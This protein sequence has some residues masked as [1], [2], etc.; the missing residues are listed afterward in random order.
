MFNSVSS[1]S[2]YIASIILFLVGFY[3]V[4]ARPNLIK[5]IIGINI[6]ETSVFLF[7]IGIGTKKNG[8][9]PIIV[10]GVK[11][12]INPLPQAVV[13]M[14]LVVGVGTTALSLILAVRLSESEKEE[15][16]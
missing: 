16:P 3:A 15:R 10:E 9:V 8:A 2:I 12:Y 7:L 6:M 11:N 5:K 13:L 1:N 4:A 14:A